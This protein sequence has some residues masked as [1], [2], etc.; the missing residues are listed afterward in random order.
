MVIL[1]NYARPGVTRSPLLAGLDQD[2]T[3]PWIGLDALADGHHICET[4]SVL[5]RPA[6][7]PTIRDA[8]NGYIVLASIVTTVLLMPH[9]ICIAV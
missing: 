6:V 1:M 5:D 7:L 9:S 3:E 4:L 2:P 8:P